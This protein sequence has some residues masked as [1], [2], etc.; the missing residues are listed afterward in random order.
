ML[1][2]DLLLFI[3]RIL[4]IVFIVLFLIEIWKPSLMKTEN[5]FM[6][7]AS[8]SKAEEATPDGFQFIRISSIK[9]AETDN[10][11][12]M[13]NHLAINHPQIDTLFWV[14][15]FDQYQFPGAIPDLPFPVRFIHKKKD[16]EL[17]LVK[18]K[19]DTVT[20]IITNHSKTD[21]VLL[22]R[23]LTAVKT[24]TKG[25]FLLLPDSL[26][27]DICFTADEQPKIGA[28]LYFKKKNTLN[29]YEE[30]YHLAHKSVALSH[31]LYN[32]PR[33]HTQLL[34]IVSEQIA[35][36]KYPEFGLSVEKDRTEIQA[37]SG[38]GPDKAL[39]KAP[40]NNLLFF[41]ILIALLC[42]RGLVYYRQQING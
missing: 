35:L 7:G 41:L 1:F 21:S 23:I 13:L 14:D 20:Y 10:G 25:A 6:V 38:S 12:I 19:I 9:Q 16:D 36:Y 17:S 2:N 5:W 39:V 30:T 15:D 11:W 22:E 4:L 29:A 33:K 42:E 8:V 31:K 32:D 27:T 18:N 40:L 28:A 3:L 34:T 24:Y 26:S 37:A